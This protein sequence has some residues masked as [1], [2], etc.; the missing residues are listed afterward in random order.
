MT[1]SLKAVLFCSIGAACLIVGLLV[2]FKV[3]ERLY[4]WHNPYL[5]QNI[6]GPT[7]LT[8]TWLEIEPQPPLKVERQLQRIALDV[9]P[10]VDT[11]LGGSEL[12]LS[13][14]SIAQVQVQLIGDDGVT[15]ELDV[16]SFL[17]AYS[18]DNLAQFS[19]QELP[20]R[21]RYIKVRLR[22]NKPVQCRS[23]F[24][25]NYN[26]WDVEGPF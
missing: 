9:G 7:T 20:A 8:S 16:H 19:R 21:H 2:T 1:R 4:Y 10:L 15:Y 26:Q 22:A 3:I 14:G 6:A 12:K 24:W 11:N 5:D 17:R 13:D 18:G 23:I 25:R